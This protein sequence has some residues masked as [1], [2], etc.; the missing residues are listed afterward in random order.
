PRAPHT[1]VGTTASCGIPDGR[2]VP[3]KVMKYTR[4]ET[5][6]D[7]YVQGYTMPH[8]IAPNGGGSLVNQ[9]TLIVDILYPDLHQGD[10]Y[11]AFI[12]IQNSVDSDADL[13]VHEESPGVG[14]IGISGRYP[15]NL[16]QG[17]WH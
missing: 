16:T 5:P 6:P 12:E 15:G 3:S 4:N 17:Q 2:G 8:G 10:Q 1:P 14:G 13:A 9:W 11:S 7:N